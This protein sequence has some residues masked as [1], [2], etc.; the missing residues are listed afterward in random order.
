MPRDGVV[1]EAGLILSE[2]LILCM[3]VMQCIIIDGW[4][5]T[6]IFVLAFASS[7]TKE[8]CASS[9]MEIL[10]HH[11]GQMICMMFGPRCSYL[12]KNEQLAS[13]IVK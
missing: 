7:H 11:V 10:I 12:R 9:D 8:N 6:H 5:K 2:G 13:D 1:L 4:I 3:G